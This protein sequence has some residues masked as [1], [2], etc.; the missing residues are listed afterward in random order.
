MLQQKLQKLFTYSIH[1]DIIKR[2]VIYIERH[3]ESFT[4]L[5]R[6]WQNMKGCCYNSRDKLY[7]YYGA[8]GITICDEWRKSYTHFRDWA[9]N[10]GYQE[11]LTIDRINANGNYEPDNCRWVDL[12]IQGANRHNTILITFNGATHTISEWAKIYNTSR[13]K[14]YKQYHSGKPFSECIGG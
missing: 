10:N 1:Y 5:Y 8:R 7:K 3:F 12:S 4:R 13:Y 11:D 6:I 14:L 9:M 2:E